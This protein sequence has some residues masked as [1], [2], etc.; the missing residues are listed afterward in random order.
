[1]KLRII[2]FSLFVPI[3]LWSQQITLEQCYSYGYY[4]HPS[5]DNLRVLL[6]IGEVEAENTSVN[7]LPQATLKA[8][9]SW[10]SDVTEVDLPIPGVN[11]PSIAHDWYKLY[12]DVTQTIY[13]GGVNRKLKQAAEAKTKTELH[14]QEV[15]LYA[16]K[17]G[18]N[19]AFFA[20][21][22]LQK[23]NAV[24]NLKMEV[25]EKQ[26]QMFSSAV[27]N[28]MLNQN[29]LNNL[30]A[31]KVLL[32]QQLIELESAQKTAL[33]NLSHITGIPI[34][35]NSQ[36]VLPVEPKSDSIS[37]IIS[38]PEL[39]LIDAQKEQ[40]NTQS[41]LLQKARKPKVYGYGQAGYGRP[42]LNMFNDA[43][44]D[45]YVVGVGMQWKIYDWKETARKRELL[46]L[47]N[48]II[49]N[50]KDNF[51]YQLN[52]LTQTKLNE[53][54]KLKRIIKSDEELLRLR[55]S[56]AENSASQL[57]NGLITSSEYIRNL[58]SF[59]SS[60]HMSQSHK[61]QLLKAQYE[62]KTLMGTELN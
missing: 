6:K 41:E 17:G 13:D 14:K 62:F 52:M 45:W 33:D 37:L 31:E 28:G 48:E 32:Q 50:S 36:L 21:L 56:V 11:L 30:L 22:N 2:I 60:Q 9:V 16:V 47:Q 26:I 4:N 12:I 39:D 34:S 25:L 3:F 27:K 5:Y 46:V 59:V 57:Q 15:N 7:M 24:L 54:E 43:F 20:A 23:Q 61:I 58:N 53:I 10:Q 44:D 8:N 38:R 49:D 35:N 51:L 18:V 29:E 19:V 1:M 42:G 40:L 55:E